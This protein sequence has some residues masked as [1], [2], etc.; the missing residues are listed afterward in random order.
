MNHKVVNIQD[1]TF[2]KELGRGG[3]GE[4]WLGVHNKSEEQ[5]AIKKL[6]V[7]LEI[8]VKKKFSEHYKR[9]VEILAQCQFPCV[10][11]LFGYTLSEPFCIITPFI[12]GGSLFDHLIKR[13]LYP[14]LDPTQK[15]IIAMGI[16]YAMMRLHDLNIIHRDLKS[17]NVL[18]DSNLLPVVCDFGISKVVGESPTQMTVSIGTPHWM[19]PEQFRSN[20]YD[21]KVD[22]Y[23]FAILLFEM[24]TEKL[25]FAGM[26]FHQVAYAVVEKGER[27]KL[28]RKGNKSIS[29]VI[30]LCWNQNPK[31]RPTFRDIFFMFLKDKAKWDGT[32]SN[33]VLE[34][35][36]S[37]MEKDMEYRRT[38]TKK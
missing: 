11:H 18:L 28:P 38:T 36:R 34:F 1:F 24:L 26:N 14:P 4:V 9:E 3:C 8:P 27:P 30:K 23:S 17:M 13:S 10:L 7:D 32:D 5:F 6:Y 29:S 33:R 19:A 21:E 15:T 20:D 37:L 22:V 12:S 31:K 25:P 35:S 2:V 16:T